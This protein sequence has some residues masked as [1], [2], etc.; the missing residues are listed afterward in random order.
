MRSNFHSD[1]TQSDHEI[2]K[3]G[4]RTQRCGYSFLQLQADGRRSFS[5]Q[6]Q[7][8]AGRRLNVKLR[9][10][11]IQKMGDRHSDQ[12]ELEFEFNAARLACSIIAA[13]RYDG[14]VAVHPRRHNMNVVAVCDRP[15][16]LKPEVFS[17]EPGHF[18]LV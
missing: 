9:P 2:T 14:A 11:W 18:G 16:V 17:V 15:P 1:G 6:R 7:L 13:I 12:P 10:L 5:R 8:L 4:P 3:G